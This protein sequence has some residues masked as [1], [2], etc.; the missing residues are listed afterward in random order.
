MFVYDHQL[1]KGVYDHQIDKGRE[2]M[3]S[4][5]SLA[6]YMVKRVTFWHS[7]SIAICNF[8]RQCVVIC[9]KPSLIQIK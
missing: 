6:S 4:I 8:G 9:L 2:L 3:I 1:I 7:T 5:L